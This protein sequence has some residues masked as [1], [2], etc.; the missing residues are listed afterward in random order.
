MV[1][2]AIR[3]CNHLCDSILPFVHFLCFVLPELNVDTLFFG[4]AFECDQENIARLFVQFRRNHIKINI[5][6]DSISVF[7]G[8]SGIL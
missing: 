6:N 7:E 2:L 4:K 1:L 3:L 5:A 8:K